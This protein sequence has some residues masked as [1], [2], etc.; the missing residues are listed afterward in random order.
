MNDRELKTQLERARQGDVNAFANVFEDHR[1]TVYAIA[2]RLAGPDDADD[3]VMETYLK[4]WR[5]LPRFHRRAALKTWLYRIAHNC[6]MDFIRARSRRQD[7]VLPADEADERQI[8]DL[9]DERQQSPAAKILQKETASMVRRALERLDQP[10]RLV[11]LLRYADELSYAEI[12]ATAGVSVGTV[13][14]RL[15]NAKRKLKNAIINSEK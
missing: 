7:R 10:H 4:A 5:A 13:M 9:E 2:C 11:L 15:F 6:A 1:P 3:I 14:S 8:S 12:A